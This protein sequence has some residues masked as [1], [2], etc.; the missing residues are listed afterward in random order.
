MGSWPWVLSC[1]SHH[2]KDL[3]HL[4]AGAPASPAFVAA[5]HT[6][7][8]TLPPYCPRQEEEQACNTTIRVGHFVQSNVNRS[9]NGCFSR[10]V[11][12]SQCL[13]KIANSGIS[14]L[15]QSCAVIGPV[16][17]SAPS[18]LVQTVWTQPHHALLSCSTRWGK[19]T[20]YKPRFKQQM[21][22]TCKHN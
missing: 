9:S 7:H 18:V 6:S 11:M 14:S 5:S 13:S 17:W 2:S 1:R 10:M 19:H 3:A 12:A 20:K 21:L 22:H 8:D 4:L 15:T 16:L